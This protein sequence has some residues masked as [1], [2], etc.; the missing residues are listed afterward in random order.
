MFGCLHGFPAFAYR[1]TANF[2]V[3]GLGTWVFGDSGLRVWV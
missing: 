2:R 3:Q 1:K